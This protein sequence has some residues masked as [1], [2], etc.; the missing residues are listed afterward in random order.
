MATYKKPHWYTHGWSPNQITDEIIQA[1]EKETKECEEFNKEL[2]NSLQVKHKQCLEIAKEIWGESSKEYKYLHDKSAPWTPSF[3][4]QLDVKNKIKKY[5]DE[6]AR[7]KMEQEQQKTI[8]NMTIQATLYLTQRNIK[9]EPDWDAKTIIGKADT[10]AFDEKVAELQKD[11]GPFEFSGSDNCEGC[12]GWDGES[13]R[14]N[15]GNRRVDWV[16]GYGF[17]FLNPEVYAEAY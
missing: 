12:S 10:I 2:R 3:S 14:C 7:L 15:C 6:Q 8:E 13:H 17:S 9:I 1:W 11:G 16:K 5:I 4:F